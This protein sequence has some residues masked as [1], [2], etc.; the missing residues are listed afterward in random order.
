MAFPNQQ[1]VTHQFAGGGE[2]GFRP[3]FLPVTNVERAVFSQRTVGL[4]EFIAWLAVHE[5]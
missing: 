2:D 4:D 5:V 3:K 1:I